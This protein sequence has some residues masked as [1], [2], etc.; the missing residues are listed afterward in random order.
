MSVTAA[1]TA[2]VC[3]AMTDEDED[4]RYVTDKRSS[5]WEADTVRCQRSMTACRWSGVVCNWSFRH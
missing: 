2:A 1:A 3:R 5:G 4:E